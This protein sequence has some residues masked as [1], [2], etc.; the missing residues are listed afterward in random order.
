MEQ[1]INHGNSATNIWVRVKTPGPWFAAEHVC[2]TRDVNLHYVW[3][4]AVYGFDPSPS[5]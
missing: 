2:I 4:V 3:P 1:S 5:T